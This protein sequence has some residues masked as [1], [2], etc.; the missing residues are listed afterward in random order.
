M[1]GFWEQFERNLAEFEEQVE[2]PEFEE[3]LVDLLTDRIL[4]MVK[5]TIENLIRQTLFQP[6]TIKQISSINE[7]PSEVKEE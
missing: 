1:S 2:K 4:E 6:K 7:F 5:P 3:K